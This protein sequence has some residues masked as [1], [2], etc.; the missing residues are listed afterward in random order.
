MS[1]ALL[2]YRNQ[3]TVRLIMSHRA[4][5]QGRMHT[6]MGLGD[7]ELAATCIAVGR[8]AS[9]WLAPWVMQHRRYPLH[10]LLERLWLSL[11]LINI[12]K[13]RRLP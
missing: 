2:R 12:S 4:L 6:W 3:A 5:L 11:L 1:S 7:F 9:L 13:R 8:H 10:E